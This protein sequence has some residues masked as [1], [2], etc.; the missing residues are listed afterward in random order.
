MSLD[1]QP[2]TLQK[3]VHRQIQ[4]MGRMVFDLLLPAHCLKCASPVSGGAGVCPTCFTAITWLDA[5]ACDRCGVLLDLPAGSYTATHRP[6]CVDCQER[7][8]PFAHSR[9]VMVY[10][11]ASRDIVLRLKHTDRIDAVP[12]LARWMARAGA[13]L[14]Q[15]SP[16][17]IPVPLHWRRLFQRRYNQAALLA[18]AL[19]RH[20]T[21]PYLPNSLRRTRHTLSQGSFDHQDSHDSRQ[22]R[23]RNIQGAFHLAHP[24]KIAGRAVVLIDDVMTTGATVAECASIL[25]KHGALSV[26]VLVVARAVLNT[27]IRQ[28]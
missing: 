8:P 28:I 14:L 25:L 1:R 26:D 18:R 11:D 21:L 9:A 10:D 2:W 13:D 15:N 12:T 3:T 17:L 19:A 6:C 23:Q 7:P 20:N 5:T 24:D 27:P 4:D 22:A 16:L